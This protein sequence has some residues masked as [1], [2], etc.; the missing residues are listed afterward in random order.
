MKHVRLTRTFTVTGHFD[1]DGLDAHTD[2]VMEELLKLEDENVS[3]SD[4]SAILA[5]SE[6]SVTV[7]AIA[8]TFD[9]AVQLADSTIRAAIHAAGGSTPRW[10]T[11]VFDP[12]SSE[13]ELVP[14]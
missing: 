14:A 11:P 4:I 5:Q 13:A 6:V 10:K 8:M 1:E 2:L 7:V 9:D 12:T 3:D